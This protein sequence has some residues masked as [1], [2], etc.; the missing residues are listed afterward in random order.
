MKRI[1]SF[2][3]AALLAFGVAAPL[4]HAAPADNINII[5]MGGDTGIFEY[6]YGDPEHTMIPLTVPFFMETNDGNIA[7]CLESDKSQ[8]MGD[9]YNISQAFYSE[10]VQRGVRAILLHG[11]PNDDGGLEMTAAWYATQVAIW[12]W[13][14]E[15]GGVG[16]PFYAQ[17]R[18]HP[19]A[20]NQAVYDYYLALLGYAWAGNDHI[21]GGVST[22]VTTLTP[23]GSGQLVGTTEI[24]FSVY[25][26]YRIDQSKLPPGITATGVTYED[27]DTITI[28]APMSYIGQ[29][30]E[31]VDAI[32]LLD[33]RSTANVFWYEAGAGS[34][35]KMV[36]FNYEFQDVFTGRLVFTSE[37]IPQ[38]GIIY[39]N[40]SNRDKSKGDYSL[41]GAVYRVFERNTG[42]SVA[43]IIT[44][45][46]G[47][48]QT[49][50]LPLVDYHM[51]EVAAPYGFLLDDAYY[52]AHFT[53]A[54][55]A[56]IYISSSDSPQQGKI[57]IKKTNADTAMGNHSLAGA[58]FEIFSGSALV[59]T[60]TT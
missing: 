45:A 48:A 21:N 12:T 46:D 27:G 19:V 8:P 7:F 20:G 9:G 30:I 32:V 37:D 44:D 38:T 6:D 31:A 34:L 33:T 25:Q 22:S 51:R 2:L 18:L 55:A 14:L 11:L 53:E 58:V 13:M 36:V 56:Q 5:G 49:G 47:Y 28:T 23:N 39:L 35:Q 17:D 3:I 43:D 42:K 50:P 52:T 40:K 54:G 1:I 60:I 26:G 4:A 16:Y 59:D 24:N 41:A 29:S 57:S 10:N 15:A